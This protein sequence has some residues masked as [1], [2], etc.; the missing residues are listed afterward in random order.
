MPIYEYQCDQ[1]GET[2]DV[3]QKFS[4]AP[5]ETCSTCGGHMEKLMSMN[6]FQLK[7]SGWYVTDYVAKN[8]QAKTDPAKAPATG[9]EG[10]ADKK[11]EP[12]KEAAP[13]AADKA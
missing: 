9:Q 7:G 6:S 12:P 5:L 3:L 2:T 11:S 10:A 1:C 4:D 13:K 8:G